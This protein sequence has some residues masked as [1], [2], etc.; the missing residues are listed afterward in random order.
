MFDDDFIEEMNGLGSAETSV[1]PSAMAQKPGETYEQM[2]R[3][4]AKKHGVDPDLIAAM[5]AQESA[6]KKA[7]K[8]WAE[9]SGLM[10]LMPETARNLGV[11]DIYDPE[12]NIDAGVRYMKQM[13]QKFNGDK[14]R[15]LVGY[16]AGPANAGRKDWEHLAWK[17]W[18]NLKERRAIPVSQRKDQYAG[19]PGEY[20]DKILKNAK[21]HTA[22]TKM[23]YGFSD[24]FIEEMNNLGKEPGSVEQKYPQPPLVKNG[25]QTPQVPVAAPIA[26]PG[27]VT[28][29]DIMAPN[30]D[31]PVSP[32]AE[33]LVAPTA[34]N[35]KPFLMPSQVSEQ[36][37][38][39][40]VAQSAVPALSSVADSQVPAAPVGPDV[41]V[42]APQIPFSDSLKQVPVQ[43]DL[44]GTFTDSRIL[45]DEPMPE[46][47]APINVGSGDSDDAV[48]ETISVN[49]EGR[50]AVRAALVEL[51]RKY[52]IDP[53]RI[54]AAEQGLTI[55]GNTGKINVTYGDLKRMG[56]DVEPIRAE[57]RAQQRIERPTLDLSLTENFQP[58]S[59]LNK[60]RGITPEQE[61]KENLEADPLYQKA[62]ANL[63]REQGIEPS[64]AFPGD[65]SDLDPATVMD[66]YLRL[67]SNEKIKLG[68]AVEYGKQQGQDIGSMN[69]GLLTAWQG[70][71]NTGAGLSKVFSGGQD[72]DLTRFLRREAASVGSASNV[73]REK[74]KDWWSFTKRAATSVPGDLLRL[75]MFLRAGGP[76]V[77][78]ATAG[79]VEAGGAGEDAETQARRALSGGISGAMFPL[80]RVLGK[81]AGGGK[82]GSAIDLATVSGGSYIQA[83]GETGG[84]PQAS[85]E[86]G[87]TMAALDV[88]QRVMRMK[89][90]PKM[91]IGPATGKPRPDG[92]EWYDSGAIEPDAA[93][94]KIFNYRDKEAGANLFLTVNSKGEVVVTGKPSKNTPITIYDKQLSD[95]EIR[96]SARKQMAAIGKTGGD[97]TAGPSMSE[98]GRS[99]VP[100]PDGSPVKFPAEVTLDRSEIIPETD[101][102]GSIPKMRMGDPVTPITDL[103]DL[104]PVPETQTAIDRQTEAA[105]DP[106]QTERIAVMYAG[107]QA[108]SAP[109]ADK[110]QWRLNLKNGDV[111][112]VDKEGWKTKAAELGLKP[113][114]AELVKFTGLDSDSEGTQKLLG[115][116]EA[117]PDTSVADAVV[118][119]E[120]GKQIDAAVTTSPET[121][122]AQIESYREQYPTADVEVKPTQQVAA[123]RIADKVSEAVG[124]PISEKLRQFEERSAAKD[125]PTADEIAKTVLPESE[126][127]R[128]KALYDAAKKVGVHV[129]VEA[130]S[131]PLGSVAVFVHGGINLDPS[132]IR[133]HAND[134]ARFKETLDHE[135]VHG[136]INV[137]VFKYSYELHKD[138]DPIFQVIKANADSASPEVQDII[139]YIKEDSLFNDVTDYSKENG[140]KTGDLEEL[141]TYAFT[142]TEFAKFLDSIPYE[143]KATGK[144]TVFAE[145]KKIIRDLIGKVTGRTALD[146]IETSLNKYFDIDWID[147]EAAANR[148]LEKEAE[149][150]SDSPKEP[151]VA[152][153]SKA[154]RFSLVKDLGVNANGPVVWK[155][156]DAGL[157][158]DNMQ[159]HPYTEFKTKRHAENYIAKQENA[160]LTEPDSGTKVDTDL[161]DAQSAVRTELENDPMLTPKLNIGDVVYSKGGQEGEVVYAKGDTVAVQFGDGEPVTYEGVQANTLSK[162][163]RPKDLPKDFGSSNTVF[164]K[165]RVEELRLQREK[166]KT[167]FRVGFEPR[168]F[169]EWLEVGGFYVEGG[170]R[171]FADFANRMVSEFGDGIRPYLR[172]VYEA[173]RDV[174]EFDSTGMDQRLPQPDNEGDGGVRIRQ[175]VTN[176]EERGLVP[177]GVIDDQYR[178]RRVQHQDPMLE[179][180]AIQVDQ[181]GIDRAVDRAMQY[182]SGLTT[183]QAAFQTEVQIRLHN[184]IRDLRERGDAQSEVLQGMLNELAGV[185]ASA[186][187]ET[188]RVLAFQK[189]LYSMIPGSAALE[190][191]AARRRAGI[192]MELTDLERTALQDASDLMN[193]TQETLVEANRLADESPTPENQT[194]RQEAAKAAAEAENKYKDL[195]KHLSSPPDSLIRKFVQS[196]K[197]A[198]V[199]AVN[200]AITNV[201]SAAVF[202][203]FLRYRDVIDIAASKLAGVA[204]G[205][206]VEGLLPAGDTR[207]THLQ[208][209]EQVTLD[210]ESVRV[211]E[212]N[213]ADRQVK[214]VDSEGRDMN[215]WFDYDML[216]RSLDPGSLGGADANWKDIAGLGDD[217]IRRTFFADP[218][219]T[220]AL[221]D[222]PDFV[223]TLYGDYMSDIKD[224]EDVYREHGGIAHKAMDTLLLGLDK[225]NIVN[226]VQEYYIRDLEVLYAL[227]ARLGSRGLSITDME[228]R[229]DFRQITDADWEYAINRARQATFSMK[230]E[231]GTMAAGFIDM[232]NKGG[233]VPALVVAPFINFSWNVTNLARDFV[234]VLA[235]ARAMKNVY[236]REG[237]TTA[238][239]IKA[240]FQPKKYTTKELANSLAGFTSFAVAYQMVSYLGD[241]DDWYY[242]RIPGTEGKGGIGPDGKPQ[243]IYIDMRS[244]PQFAPFLFLANKFNRA[245]NGKALFTYTDHLSIA[246]EITEAMASLS[247]RSGIERNPTIQM[248]DSA[249]RAGLAKAGGDTD[250]KAKQE[251]TH[252]LFQFFGNHTGVYLSPMRPLKNLIDWATNA[253]SKDTSASPAL[254]SMARNV[255]GKLL[256]QFTAVP[257]LT[258][259]ATDKPK[260]KR[261]DI[262][263]PFGLTILDGS[264]IPKEP[265][266]GELSAGAMA[267]QSFVGNKKPI[268]PQD[269]FIVDLKRDFERESER[270]RATGN[271]AGLLE[272][273]DKLKQYVA[274]GK[275]EQKDVDSIK[276]N[277]YTLD[278]QENFSRLSAVPDKSA[279]QSQID[280]LWPKLSEKEKEILM[281]ALLEKI[282]TAVREGKIKS[283]QVPAL[284][285]F[286]VTSE[287]L[288]SL[289]NVSLVK[290][291]TKAQEQELIDRVKRGDDTALAG[292]KDTEKN[293]ILREAK[294]PQEVQDFMGA[295]VTRRSFVFD[296]LPA[297]KQAVLLPYLERS[298]ETIQKKARPTR[299]DQL[300]QADLI[301]AKGRFEQ[302]MSTLSQDEKLRLVT[303][304]ATGRALIDSLYKDS[305]NPRGSR[306]SRGGRGSRPS[307]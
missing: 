185:R 136:L 297:E 178:F 285:R 231:H 257:D 253:P 214:L 58:E 278:L 158:G 232:M 100:T 109:K 294:L 27:Q 122:A 225:A 14:R 114:K 50:E 82:A 64:M 149:P 135:I 43:E 105:A 67:Q 128:S 299:E 203:G 63:L 79:M 252:S 38:P 40:A 93:V 163:P 219:V 167:T 118:A 193:S 17:K 228:A 157:T 292:L 73:E 36:P 42:T 247:Y 45:D 191:E 304:S 159:T 81:I 235:Q 212:V 94:G 188:G 265:S 152:V 199:A 236:N 34:Y 230:P 181:L 119:S 187:S 287:S 143:S 2:A 142:N 35:G 144:T 147:K 249:V 177:H 173:I 110:T 164:T 41:A 227:Q 224:M 80:G 302:K 286:G 172:M 11:K 74:N 153:D 29:L 95:A 117:V 57:R 47:Q 166:N 245:M 161:A 66:E 242:L 141:I 91:G 30:F 107:E 241:R 258:D 306:P 201:Q 202:R 282:E 273:E 174:P 254:Q 150:S 90:R 148:A 69:S 155:V 192:R 4:I 115:R 65:T 54:L 123:D 120:G 270:R 175:G 216:K 256:D 98:P 210:G 179:A 25:E 206:P 106:A 13:L 220:Q 85:T 88:L 284:E 8:S 18:T 272:L 215:G 280:R 237:G 112:L 248:V 213:R 125:F 124:V 197:M 288:E 131:V 234:P 111:V 71:L 204:K 194:A 146:A 52:N 37:K 33:T 55:E 271:D 298:L 77:G 264:E 176:S 154:E 221:W 51:S 113:T 1:E 138:L 269:K 260:V 266:A 243:S 3:R 102:E 293:K 275:I 182:Q 133:R 279:Q 171:S 186:T 15:A 259:K 239:N 145:L 169:V 170:A 24:A 295:P 137:G 208:K 5:M 116:V 276:R 162:S 84:D 53:D 20:V 92:I 78:F 255:P 200:T 83:L 151:D 222:N 281:P 289:R 165:A 283:D 21:N 108:A 262:L 240:V 46:Q 96:E 76:V 168:E 268:L 70:F 132:V 31:R 86:A 16:N 244:H 267:R 223:K 99:V 139:S 233:G 190:V 48:V 307:R 160:A 12:Q 300:N 103:K 127:N 291:G 49:G 62:K 263:K 60:I 56:V 61:K 261:W 238:E 97:T 39:P 296:N 129:N 184:M 209:G 130:G 250:E 226:R 121:A 251:F 7:A 303:I 274:E 126:Y 89:S 19:S 104:G 217:Y 140:A 290:A 44:P 277:M 207:G 218:L 229:K 198:M 75:A 68:Q 301:K 32:S 6:G 156:Y 134:P 196:Q 101:F 9:A 195:K 87:V 211:K 246:N 59:T 26:A 189:K 180:A 10:Q 28:P 22:F 205:T 23:D 305:S 72:N 183:E